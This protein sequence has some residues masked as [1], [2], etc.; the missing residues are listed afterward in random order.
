MRHDH[1]SVYMSDDFQKEVRFLGIESSPAFV[2]QPE[3]NGCI[4][5]FFRT[6]KEQSCSGSDTFA[7]SMSFT[8]R[9]SSSVTAI[10]ITGSLGAS[11]IVRRIRPGVIS[12]L[13]CP[14][15]R[16]SMSQLTPNK[17]SNPPGPKQP[18][19]GPCVP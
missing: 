12:C 14:L 9:R 19:R 7:I 3:G 2:M 16:D 13:Q 10:T 17:L 1:G 11:A 5:R 8:P 6:L 18:L 15:P 4:E